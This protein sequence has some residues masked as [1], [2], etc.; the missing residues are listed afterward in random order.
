MGVSHG[1]HGVGCLMTSIGTGSPSLSFFRAVFVK[2]SSRTYRCGRS[3]LHAGL[4]HHLFPN[5]KDHS[6]ATRTY[7]GTFIVTDALTLMPAVKLLVAGH[8]A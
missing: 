8:L 2:G 7:N 3:K 4:V 6:R 1:G 5:K